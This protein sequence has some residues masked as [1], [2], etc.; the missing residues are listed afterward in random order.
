MLVTAECGFRLSP[1]TDTRVREERLSDEG[2]EWVRRMELLSSLWMDPD[3]FR[4]AFNVQSEELTREFVQGG[5]EACILAR[6]GGDVEVLA[7][8]RVA[9]LARSRRHR[10]ERPRLLKFVEAWIGWTGEREEIDEWSDD[11]AHDIKKVRRRLRMERRPSRSQSS[12][13]CESKRS[14]TRTSSRMAGT[15]VL[16]SEDA[17]RPWSG[18]GRGRTPTDD[19]PQGGQRSTGNLPASRTKP[20]TDSICTAWP[21]QNRSSHEW[22]TESW[23]PLGAPP[24]PAQA[25]APSRRASTRERSARAPAYVIRDTIHPSDRSRPP[26]RPTH[27]DGRYSHQDHS[28]WNHSEDS[29]PT[30]NGHEFADE[31]DNSDDDEEAELLGAG[32]EERHRH[33]TESIISHYRNLVSTSTVSLGRCEEADIDARLHPAFRSDAGTV[34]EDEDDDE[35]EGTD[36]DKGAYGVGEYL[37]PATFRRSQS[38]RAGPDASRGDSDA[39]WSGGSSTTVRGNTIA[40]SKI[41][42]ETARARASAYRHLVGS[43]P[44]STPPPMPSGRLARR[45]SSVYSVETKDGGGV[46]WGGFGG[47]NKPK[48]DGMKRSNTEGKKKW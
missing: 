41:E 4:E 39:E 35:D 17:G 16:E 10:R 22:R 26:S 8:L 38:V 43:H 21:G 15:T 30:F 23:M 29:T 9:V 45:P 20:N 28:H 36:T 11:L 6:I 32:E 3:V 25:Q 40:A 13:R 48:G 18:G 42:S 37:A 14:K 46:G 12:R 19:E 24:P 34:C 2:R 27:V 31:G 44:L 1:L 47:K 33:P 7:D 5:C